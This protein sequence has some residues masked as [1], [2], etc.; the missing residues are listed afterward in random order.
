MFILLKPSSEGRQA[1]TPCCLTSWLA[2][3]APFQPGSTPGSP[4]WQ[5]TTS[6]KKTK[7]NCSGL[8]LVPPFQQSIPAWDETKC[9]HPRIFHKREINILFWSVLVTICRCS[10]A[11]SQK[12]TVLTVPASMTLQKH[13][14][15]HKDY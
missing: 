6:V 8:P 12:I 14:I 10:T 13:G 2:W 9:Q 11:F 1:G 5:R 4:G 7:T 15:K 3:L